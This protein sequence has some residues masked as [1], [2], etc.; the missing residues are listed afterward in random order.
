MADP[1]PVLIDKSLLHRIGVREWGLPSLRMPGQIWRSE[2]KNIIACMV[3]HDE[4]SVSIEVLPLVVVSRGEKQW[5]PNHWR[6]SLWQYVQ[7]W[8]CSGCGLGPFL[9]ITEEQRADFIRRHVALMIGN[10]DLACLSLAHD[11]GQFAAW[12][13]EHEE[14]PAQEVKP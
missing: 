12:E 11:V 6:E 10:S 8:P 7:A 3:P 1:R 13:Y 4:K 2:E 9:A 5:M 14:K